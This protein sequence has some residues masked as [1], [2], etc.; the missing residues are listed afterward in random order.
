MTSPIED[1]L[2]TMLA[3]LPPGKSV[4]AQEVAR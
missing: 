2:C 4:S 1:A 3:S